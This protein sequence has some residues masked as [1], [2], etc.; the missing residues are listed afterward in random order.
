M[1]P[2]MGRLVPSWFFGGWVA[3]RG[4]WACVRQQGWRMCARPWGECAWRWERGGARAGVL[5]RARPAAGG[6]A[7]PGACHQ[8]PCRGLR[9]PPS[10]PPGSCAAARGVASRTAPTHLASGDG[11]G[12]AQNPA[13]RKAKVGVAE[14]QGQAQCWQ[15]QA[16]CRLPARRALR[17][18]GRGRDATPLSSPAPRRT[19]AVNHLGLVEDHLAGFGG[20]GGGPK[21]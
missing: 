20:E 12:G 19:R 9:G 8:D 18:R 14:R 3:R 16:V 2:L 11:A 1:R 7:G 15:R 5:G 4:G 6:A 10:L 21:R 13:C 17:R